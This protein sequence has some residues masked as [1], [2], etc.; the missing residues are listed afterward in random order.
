MTTAA[1]SAAQAHQASVDS[2]AQDI[3]KQLQEALGQ[4]LVAR[5][6][7]LKNPQTVGEWAAGKQPRS[8]NEE[9][10]RH[11]FQVYNV[12]STADSRHT[13]RAWFVGLN[14]MLNDNA[15]ARVISKGGFR[16]VLTAAKSYVQTG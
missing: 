2:T 1:K 7:N 15:P 12:L 5:M 3:A 11:I 10:L 14:P 9:G 8:G 16:D 4:K 13:I 6:L